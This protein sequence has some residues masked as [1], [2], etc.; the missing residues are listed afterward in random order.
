MWEA[1]VRIQL[2]FLHFL[3]RQFISGFTETELKVD[4]LQKAYA[5]KLSRINGAG[6][7]VESKLLTMIMHTSY[8]YC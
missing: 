5:Q 1:V 6:I 8:N 7:G 2:D 3:R 4:L